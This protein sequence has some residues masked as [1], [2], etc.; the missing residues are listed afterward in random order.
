MTHEETLI[1]LSS[2]GL[3]WKLSFLF[4]TGHHGQKVVLCISH[5]AVVQLLK[6]LIVLCICCCNP[7]VNL[8]VSGVFRSI[9]GDKLF[10]NFSDPLCVPTLFLFCSTLKHSFQSLCFDFKLFC[11]SLGW[12]LLWYEVKKLMSVSCFHTCVEHEEAVK[13]NAYLKNWI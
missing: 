4:E 3:A 6:L 13:S 2:G 8:L 1:S 11:C 12:A 7:I 10:L 5:T 9:P